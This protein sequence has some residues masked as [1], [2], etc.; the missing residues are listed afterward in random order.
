MST[1]G[2]QRNSPR[3]PAGKCRLPYGLTLK[4][5]EY[6]FFQVLFLKQV[7]E[8]TPN[9]R[10]GDKPLL[11]RREKNTRPIIIYTHLDQLTE[12]LGHSSCL[13]TFYITSLRIFKAGWTTSTFTV[14]SGSLPMENQI[15][16]F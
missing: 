1:Q 11:N 9:S 16:N 13:Y 5:P 2:H 6:Y 12:Q 8:A 15:P 4:I 7:A 3:Q 14:C 10:V